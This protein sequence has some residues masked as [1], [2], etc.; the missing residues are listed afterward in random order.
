MFWCWAWAVGLKGG[1]GVV[2][3]TV[4]YFQKSCSGEL[5]RAL[6]DYKKY[7][8]AVESDL[9]ENKLTIRSDYRGPCLHL[10]EPW[11]QDRK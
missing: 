8:G 11:S 10:A 7:C 1:I 4:G 9:C 3:F 5:P 6:N 2:V